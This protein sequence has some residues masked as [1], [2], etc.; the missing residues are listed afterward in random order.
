[1]TGGLTLSAGIGPNFML[2]KIAADV[3]KPDGQTVIGSSPEVVAAFLE[4]LPC[5]KV[6]GVGRVTEQKLAEGLDVNTVG[7]LREKLP[8]VLTVFPQK[9]AD[10]LIRVSQGIDLSH[11]DDNT[12]HQ[13]EDDDDENEDDGNERSPPSS[14]SFEAPKV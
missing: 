11:D 5:R 12:E 7:D 2:A 13:N 8:E 1:V 14:S 6:G 9:L 4:N 3:R 10:F